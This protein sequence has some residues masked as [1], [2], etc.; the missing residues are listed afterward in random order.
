MKHATLCNDYEKGKLSN[1]HIS[2]RVISLQYSWV[3]RLHESNFQILKVIPLY[4]I[5][6]FLGQTLLF[7]SKLILKRKS[8]KKFPNDFLE[9]Q[10]KWG[11]FLFSFSN[12]LSA[13]STQAVWCNRYLKIDNNTIYNHYFSG[14]NINHIISWV[15]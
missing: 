2:V 11:D 12:V 4:F 14:K 10:A 3:K 6:K 7:D 1:E 9:I 8:V 13:V 15:F 5:K